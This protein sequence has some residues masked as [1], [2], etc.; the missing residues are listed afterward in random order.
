LRWS[1]WTFSDIYILKLF[2]YIY[3]Y[4][5]IYGEREILVAVSPPS[6]HNPSST[7]IP[8]KSIPLPFLFRKGKAFLAYQPTMEYQVS[9]KVGTSLPIKL[10]KATL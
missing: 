4:I 2:K 1:V 10:D 9:I 8:F 7:P 6:S 3:I 5:Y